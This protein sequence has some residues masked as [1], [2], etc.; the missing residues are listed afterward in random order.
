[1]PFSSLQ[2]AENFQDERSCTGRCV[3]LNI[4]TGNFSRL[5]YIICIGVANSSNKYKSIT[6]FGIQRQV[7]SFLG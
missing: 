5:L 6:L 1:V 3:Q 4:T 2:H 7:F